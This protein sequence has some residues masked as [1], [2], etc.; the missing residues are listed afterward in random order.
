MQHTLTFRPFP[1]KLVF[2]AL[3][4]AILTLAIVAGFTIYQ[5][6]RPVFVGLGGQRIPISQAIEDRY[7][8]RLT[9]VG[10]TARDGFIDMRYRVID[11]EKATDFG[12]YPATTPMIIAEDSGAEITVTEMGLHNHR[13]QPGLIFHVMYRNTGNAAQRGRPVTVQVGDM[14]IQHIIVQ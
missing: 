13:M 11:A 12:H 7:G 14:K 4:A 6:T 8:I 10:L 2:A 5:K 1:R 3:A 9:F